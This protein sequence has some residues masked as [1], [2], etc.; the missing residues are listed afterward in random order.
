MKASLLRMAALYGA[1]AVALFAAPAVALA[2]DQVPDIKGKWVGKTHTIV[3]G[4][5]AH[6]PANKGT[7]EKP[8]LF[9]K[10]LV[11]D[12]AGQDG[13]RFWGVFTISG[14]GETTIE[15]F[16]GQLTGSDNKTV[17][18]ADTDGYL[19]GRIDGEAISFCYAQ[20]GGRNP[21][22]AVVSCS[23]VKQAR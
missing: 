16:V 7:F 20:A 13:R 22:P 12:V 3:A 11:I 5:G 10:D 19:N 14:G 21:P 8:G 15:P 9:E 23:E 1:A 4:S 2:A 6:W 18:I 17:V